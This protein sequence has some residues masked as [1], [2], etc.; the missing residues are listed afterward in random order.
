M[1]TITKLIAGTVVGAGVIAGLRYFTNI[2]RAQAQLQIVPNMYVHKLSLEGLVLRIDALLKNPTNATFTLKY[3]FIEITHKKILVGSSQ[4]VNK[5][6]RIPAFGQV[7]IQ[8]MMVSIP[9]IGF[10]SVVFDLVTS[11]SNREPVIL[12]VGV[13]TTV[14]LG[15]T[16]VAYE[17]RQDITLKSK[18]KAK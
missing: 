17:H 12:N 7:L 18:R 11:L 15:W 5:D 10:V 14:D 3:P 13:I 9:V 16:Q 8:G 1:T 4:V 6:I 2:E